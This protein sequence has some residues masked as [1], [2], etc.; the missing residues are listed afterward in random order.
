MSKV[1]I[2]PYK[3]KP[4][5]GP[6][7]RDDVSTWD[8]N[9]QSFCRQVENWSQFLLSG[10]RQNWTA[11]DEDPT[12]GLEADT[13]EATKKLRSTF[14]D[15][16]TCVATSC[17]TGFMATIMRESTS[18]TW[19]LQTIKETF[20]LNTKGKDFLQADNI[21]F[22]FNQNFTYQQGY[23]Q[24][25]DFYISSLLPTNTL[26]KGKTR[27]QTEVLSPL[28]EQFIIK[29]WL[30]KIDPRLPYHIRK[31]R[32]HLFTESRS[33]LACLQNILN[34]QIDTMLA[35]L[36]TKTSQGT[37]NLSVGQVPFIYRDNTPQLYP[38]FPNKQPARGYSTSGGTFKGAPTTRNRHLGPA[39]RQQMACTACVRARR[40]D[41][42]R[43]HIESNCIWQQQPTQQ[44]TDY[45][46]TAAILAG[47]PWILAENPEQHYPDTS[48]PQDE[49]FWT[50]PQ[51]KV[52]LEQIYQKQYGYTE[53]QDQAFSQDQH[54]YYDMLE[55]GEQ[56][57]QY[58]DE[59]QQ[60]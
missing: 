43:T 35:E 27:T 8:Y 25:R 44:N 15:F 37:Y 57:Y 40:Y 53:K 2:K 32:G 24:I 10:T 20:G 19:V 49:V 21:K 41:E 54:T 16:L 13:E 23:M 46:A 5:D 22:T 55:E 11:T 14:K 48:A 60:L 26:F 47:E 28:A 52:P 34:D 58:P 18:Y 12:N 42:A 33:T 9:L 1:T 50:L 6:M 59:T 31:T 51:G 39:R 4:T 30:I 38:K 29:E 7:S 56:H 17:P 3:L 45:D 36:D